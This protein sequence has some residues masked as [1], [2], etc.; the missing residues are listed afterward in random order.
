MDLQN[1]HTDRLHLR[2]L[3]EPDIPAVYAACQDPEIQRWT[4]VPSPYRPQDAEEFVGQY[5][6]KGWSED[7]AYTFGLF[8][9]AGGAE[10]EDGGADG[11]LAG[12]IGLMSRGTGVY[13]I[14]Y[15]AVPE[16]RGHGYVHEAAVRVCHWAFDTLKAR[17]V[18]W[19]AT[20]GNVPSRA[21]AEKAGFRFE[22]TLR[23]AGLHQGAV[24]NE[25]I[26]GLIPEDLAGS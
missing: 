24:H 15:W 21:V 18:E 9:K 10:P 26:A 20:E 5:V 25:W 14:G 16:Q 1:L 4:T 8:P 12:A 11:E 17:R 23:N 6:P 3:S 22:G 2:P 7:T 19:R 13:E